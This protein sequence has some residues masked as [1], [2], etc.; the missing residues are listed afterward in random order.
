MVQQ[1]KLGSFYESIA[2]IAIGASIALIAQ[3][4]VFPTEGIEVPLDSH[5]RITA[6]FTV[7]SI[8]RSYTIRRWFNAK[9]HRAAMKLAERHE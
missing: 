2:N 5:L 7:I 1:T 9:L 4:F 3:M 8:V 6:W